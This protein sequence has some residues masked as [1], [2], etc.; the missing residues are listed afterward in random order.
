M[1]PEPLPIGTEA[2]DFEM[3][4][5]NGVTYTLGDF[6]GHPIFVYIQ[7]SNRCPYMLAYIERIKA[8]AATY[9]DQGVQFVIVNSNDEDEEQQDVFAAMKKFDDQYE[10]NMPY[11]R[12]AD[13]S[14]AQAYRTYRTPEVLVFDADRMLRYRGRIDDNT[15]D[16][17]FIEHHDLRD[18]LDALIAGEP[19]PTPKT[20]PVGCTVKWKSG[21]E[22][23]AVTT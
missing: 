6:D 8:F 11:L 1:H 4:A 12:D 5:T 2:P 10:L 21:N 14:V 22:P 13:Q 9:S 7:G 15:Q 19:V 18:A 23:R 17:T 20:Y 16:P 3:P